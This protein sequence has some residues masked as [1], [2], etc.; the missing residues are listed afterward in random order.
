MQCECAV[1]CCHL[2]LV[3]LYIFFPHCFINGTIFGRKKKRRRLSNIKCV[4]IIPIYF[5]DIF[6]ILRRIQRNLVINVLRYSC[7]VPVILCQILMKFEFSRQIFEI[8]RV[9]PCGRR[10]G[11]RDRQT[12]RYTEEHNENNS[13]LW[14]FCELV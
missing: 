13:P 11:G 2:W 7:E 12:D 4:S 5:P 9:V 6:L 14:Q 1:I 10:E 3:S 8:N